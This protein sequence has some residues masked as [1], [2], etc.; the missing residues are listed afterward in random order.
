MARTMRSL[1]PISR[2]SDVIFSRSYVHSPS[3]LIDFV[4]FLSWVC[5]TMIS[6]DLF[7]DEFARYAS[8]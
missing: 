4:C 6:D 8:V 3:R 2:V 5:S 1:Y 7:D